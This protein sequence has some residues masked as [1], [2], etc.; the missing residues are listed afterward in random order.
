MDDVEKVKQKT[1]IVELI[2][3]YIPIKK[4]G[5]NF[6]APCPF[7]NEK[8]P[9]FVVSP[10]R[11]IWHCFG[12]NKGGDI[13]TFVEEYE[14]TTFADAL[15]YLAQKAGVQLTT[16]VARSEAEKRRDMIYSL[17]L[18]AAQFYEYILFSHPV[19]KTALR[20]VLDTRRQPEALLKTF[21][22]GYAPNTG[23]S[24]TQFLLKKKTY[25]PQDLVDAGLA[26]FAHGRL[27][28]FF[29]HR[30]MFPITDPRGNIIAFSGR[31]LSSEQ[32]PK[33]V[34]TKETAVYTKGETV[35]GLNL[36]R[37]EIKKQGSVIIMEGEFDVI[38]AH[39]EGIGNVVAVKGTA[40]TEQQIELLKRYAQKLVFCF[41]TDPAGTT[42]Q[43]RSIQLIENAGIVASVIMLPK[44]KDPDELLN[45]D[46]VEFKKAVKDDVHIYDFIINSAVNQHDVKSVDG[47]REVLA[48]TIPFLAVIDNEVIKEHYL[49]R[50]AEALDTSYDS[51][52]RQSEKEKKAERKPVVTA[53]VSKKSREEL[54][55]QHLFSLLLSST[56]LLED[57]RLVDA[58]LDGVAFPSISYQKL[59]QLLKSDIEKNEFKSLEVFAKTIPAELVEAYDVAFLAPVP[60]YDEKKLSEELKKTALELKTLAV[61][62]RLSEIAVELS[63]ETSAQTENKLQEE[64]QTLTQKLK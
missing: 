45:T 42:A 31:A 10:D 17:N 46:P 64:A 28:D 18:L 29:R 62:K 40:L 47:K 39:R 1:D 53:S 59:F 20:Y 5:R 12:C 23:N 2:E 52:F 49:K 35:F 38:S 34:N 44:G 25:Q 61:K 60:E 24:L 56:H 63:R 7:H 58:A 21:M 32:M 50:L 33:Y 43:R 19:G 6:K 30:I 11:Q 22:V 57:L 15:K 27:I 9:S 48:K 3:S 54:L 16:S 26:I 37:D 14:K 51:I 41:D 36:A 13:F 4:A 8:S 55:P